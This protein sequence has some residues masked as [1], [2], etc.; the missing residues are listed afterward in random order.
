MLKVHVWM[1]NAEHVG[2]TALTINN[3]YV[4]FWP[5][6]A[7][8]KKDLKVKRSHPGAFMT[9]L[10]DDIINEGNRQPITVTLSE[11]V[12]ESALMEYVKTLRGNTP[13]YQLARNNCSHI[14]AECLHIAC[15]KKPSFVPDASS[16]GRIVGLFLGRGIW[17]PDQI[18]KYARELAK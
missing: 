5:N 17:T 15:Q 6:G 18:L 12:N 7:A 11:G 13:R 2:H 14:V 3:V 8:G 9:S 1:P 10:Q 4:S 16:Y